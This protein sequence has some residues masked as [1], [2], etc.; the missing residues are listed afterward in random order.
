MEFQVLIRIEE[1]H[2]D[3]VSDNW[4]CLGF[5]FLAFHIH[6]SGNR[7]E[8]N[9]SLIKHNSLLLRLKGADQKIQ[10]ALYIFK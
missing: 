3:V 2:Q 9:I 6:R 1:I 4:Y 5:F 7:E 10:K 8:V